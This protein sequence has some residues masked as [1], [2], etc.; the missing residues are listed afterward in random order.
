M[1]TRT[2]AGT[3]TTYGYDGT[4]RR[5]SVAK[6]GVTTYEVYNSQGNLLIEFTPSTNKL[7][8]YMYLGGKRVVQRVRQ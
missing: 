1:T 2:I 8:E 4:S 6:A 3:T 5:V 7:I